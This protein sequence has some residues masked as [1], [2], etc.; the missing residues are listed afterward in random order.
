MVMRFSPNVLFGEATIGLLHPVALETAMGYI[1]ALSS[2]QIGYMLAN[3]LGLGQSLLT[4]WPHLTT[5]ISLSVVC[6]AV[7]Y[8][9][10]M[11]QEV[12]AT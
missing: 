5:L 8:I 9:L 2:G 11:R 10:F 1:G 7:S 6:F 12:R 4:I 3:P